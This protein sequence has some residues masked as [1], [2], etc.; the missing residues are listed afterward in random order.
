MLAKLMVAVATPLTVELDNLWQHL[1][2]EWPSYNVPD[3]IVTM[4]ILPLT[5]NG[6]VD[7]NSIKVALLRQEEL[8]LQQE[9]ELDVLEM[10]LDRTTPLEIIT[11]AMVQ[12]LSLSVKDL[13]PSPSFFALGVTPWLP[14][15]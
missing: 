9:Q 15:R 13:K 14:S 11:K 3:G 5:Q 1:R 4:D 12:S 8:R 6:K 7:M 10:K 2:C